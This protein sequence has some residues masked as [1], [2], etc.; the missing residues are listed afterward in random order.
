VSLGSTCFRC[1]ADGQ[2]EGDHPTGTVAGRHVHPEFWLPMCLACHQLRSRIDRRVGIEGGDVLTPWLLI[3]RLAAWFG[4]L[5]TA[6]RPIP[7]PPEVF[8]HL[9][10]VLLEAANLLCPSPW[11]SK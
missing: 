3:R 5:A 11:E 8:R 7:V 6:H 4:C 2:V 9:A 10:L 1:G